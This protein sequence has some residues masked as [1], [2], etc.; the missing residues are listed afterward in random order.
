MLKSLL[1]TAMLV[2]PD[3]GY[4]AASLPSACTLPSGAIAGAGP[5]SITAT[6]A[7]FGATDAKVSTMAREKQI[8]AMIREQRIWVTETDQTVFLLDVP[9]KSRRSDEII[10][11]RTM[12]DTDPVSTAI[13]KVL[14]VFVG[15][16]VC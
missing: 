6:M 16:L 4:Q 9:D 1:L 12:P 3:P 11:V 7:L 10:K 15:Q 2:N 13:G 14:Y 5:N 8:M